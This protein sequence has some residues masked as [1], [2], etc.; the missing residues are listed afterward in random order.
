VNI[1]PLKSESPSSGVGNVGKRSTRIS[2][3][4]DL[5]AGTTDDSELD[6][7]TQQNLLDQ[8]KELPEVRSD[9]ATMGVTLANDPN[10]PSDEAIDKIATLMAG[11]EPGWMD[12]IDAEPD[13]TDATGA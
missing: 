8:I 13:S 1:D 9:V 7:I 4:T 11:L 2:T 12:A 10:Y 6:N 3:S 5:N